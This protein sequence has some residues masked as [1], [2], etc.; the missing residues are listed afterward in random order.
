VQQSHFPEYEPGEIALFDFLFRWLS[1]MQQDGVLAG[2]NFSGDL[3][4]LEVK[5]GELK[6]Q[7][8]DAIGPARALEYADRLKGELER[9]GRGGG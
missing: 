5:A 7:L 2:T 9:Q 8:I 1:G 3:A 4:G 6:N